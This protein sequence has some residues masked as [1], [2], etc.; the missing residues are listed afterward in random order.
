MKF[1][2]TVAGKI[3]KNIKMIAEEGCLAFTYMW[4]CGVEPENAEAMELVSD[5]IDEGK[6]TA[7]DGVLAEPFITWLTGRK[8]TVT[9]K[10]ITTIKDIKKRTPVFY[11]ID[12][13]TGHWVGVENGKIIFNSLIS[14]KNVAKGKPISARI[15]TLV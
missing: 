15:I 5:A 7:K 12:G 8:V 1:P 2:Q 11:S 6:I 9:K 14:S 10:T 13:K 4:C 3:T